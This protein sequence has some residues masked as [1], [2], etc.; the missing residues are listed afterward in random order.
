M[1]RNKWYAST[2]ARATVAI[3][4]P[5]SSIYETKFAPFALVFTGSG[6]QQQS[7]S[8]YCITDL[9]CFGA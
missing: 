3:S 4:I 1:Q 8:T 9:F 7:S 2:T 5:Y 6:G